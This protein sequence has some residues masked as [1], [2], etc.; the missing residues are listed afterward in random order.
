MYVL[1]I[2]FFVNEHIEETWL[3]WA[4]SRFFTF[5]EGEKCFTEIKM[6]RML[7][8]QDPDHV[9]YTFQLFAKSIHEIKQYE[10]E[11]EPKLMS[12]ISSEFGEKAPIFKS[13]MEVIL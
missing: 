6:F 8:R 11:I 1:N 2:S 4:K 10:N 13:L 9:T 5:L 7:S 3:A 12:E